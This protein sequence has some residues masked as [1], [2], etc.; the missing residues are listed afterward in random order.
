MTVCIIETT[1]ANSI[2]A[3]LSE[4]AVRAPHIWKFW[5]NFLFSEDAEL[6]DEYVH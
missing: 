2:G 4:V 5:S 3:A 1:G 6:V